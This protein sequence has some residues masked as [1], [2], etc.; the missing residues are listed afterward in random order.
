M[1]D[2]RGNIIASQLFEQSELDSKKRPDSVSQ[3]V[4]WLGYTA[5]VIT[6]LSIRM[7]KYVVRLRTASHEHRAF[8]L[9]AAD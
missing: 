1:L 9:Q 3:C 6:I 4:I 8:F 2:A 7:F 5:I